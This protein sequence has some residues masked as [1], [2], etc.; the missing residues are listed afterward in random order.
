MGDK[1][2]E[3]GMHVEGR[4]REKGEERRREKGETRKEK[5]HKRRE[6]GI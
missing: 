5:G 2:W 1:N 3:T 6:K 4:H